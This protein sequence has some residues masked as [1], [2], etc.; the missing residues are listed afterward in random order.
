MENKRVHVLDHQHQNQLNNVFVRRVLTDL[1]RALSDLK[2]S[3]DSGN[4]KDLGLEMA[5]FLKTVSLIASRKFY[6][7]E[8]SSDTRL[9]FFGHSFE[10][11]PQGQNK[12][13][14]CFHLDNTSNY[15]CQIFAVNSEL[16]SKCTEV[17]NEL[18]N[19]FEIAQFELETSYIFTFTDEYWESH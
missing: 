8:P 15:L 1:L 4:P 18:A 2:L 17:V 10:S 11:M 13:M 14:V 12:V 16:L 7:M 19:I 3:D 6:F 5:D 9:K